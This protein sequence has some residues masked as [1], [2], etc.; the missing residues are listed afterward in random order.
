M[1]HL[2]LQPLA[3]F[4]PPKKRNPQKRKMEGSRAILK[5]YR[6]GREPPSRAAALGVA[7]NA[8]AAIDRAGS[9]NAMS[10][11]RGFSEADQEALANSSH[12]AREHR[13]RFP[14]CVPACGVRVTR[15][16]FRLVPR[17][18]P[19]HHSRSW[20]QR[21]QPWEAHTRGTVAASRVHTTLSAQRGS[22]PRPRA[23]V[24]SRTERK[25]FRRGGLGYS[26]DGDGG[27]GGWR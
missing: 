20:A 21:K 17:P 16:R 19:L 15:L 13:E 24:L 14:R 26:G 6:G 25:S 22:D 2:P 7:R 4:H 8:C 27:G 3:L 11:K 1:A 10:F 9:V 5:K 12:G 23:P 18:P